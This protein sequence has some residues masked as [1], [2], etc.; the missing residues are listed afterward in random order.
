[1]AFGMEIDMTDNTQPEALR[2]A[3]E[4]KL[5]NEYDSI[6]SI[7][8]IAKAESELRRQHARIAELEAQ[9]E[10]IGAGGVSGPLMGCAPIA[11]S[12]GS[13]PVAHL[14]QHSETGRTRVVLP[15]MIVDADASW[16]LVGPLFLGSHPSPQEGI[17]GGWISVDERLPQPFKEV[18]VSPRPDDYCCEA[19]CD[20]AGNW[21]WAEYEHNFGV[22]HRECHVEYWLMLPEVPAQPTT[23][24]GSGNGGES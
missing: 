4:F 19:F 24:A 3:N 2:L 22:H 9:L 16:R 1:M 15:D 13:E 6:P 10:A 23:S 20:M 18:V 12:A 7:N 5:C 21:K 8:D 14:W 11:A 17:V